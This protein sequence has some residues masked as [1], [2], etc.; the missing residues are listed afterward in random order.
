MVAGPANAALGSPDSGRLAVLWLIAI[1][2]PALTQITEAEARCPVV[3]SR[4]SLLLL[5]VER[6]AQRKNAQWI[7][8][9]LM[10]V[11]LLGLYL[12]HQYFR[13]YLSYH[14]TGERFHLGIYMYWIGLLTVGLYHWLTTAP[15]QKQVE[16]PQ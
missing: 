9:L 13:S 16:G 11:A 4:S 6:V 2:T 3:R 5:L 15:S 1:R 7:K 12:T 14:M 8:A 10:V